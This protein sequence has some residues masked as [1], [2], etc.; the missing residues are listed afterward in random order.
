MD[1]QKQIDQYILDH[2]GEEDE[3]LKELDRYTHVNV[4]WARMISGH[5]QGKVL[6]MLSNMISPA[7]I[8]EI[9]TFTGYSAICLARGL[10]KGGKLVTIEIDD[11]LKKIALEFFAK[12][13]LTDRIEQRIGPALEI[14][15]ELEQTFDLVFLDADKRE[16]MDY[17]NAVF[18]KIRTGGY[19]IADNTLWSGRVLEDPKIVDE[20]TRGIMEFNDLINNDERVEKVILPLRD[21]MTLIRK[22]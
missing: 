8:L 5:L 12:A 7:N 15:P 22:R 17:Y 10:Q 16:Y 18:P 13:K 21:G 3:V 1:K 11:Q 20:Q 6:T 14:I 9:G 19:I 4:L 2:I